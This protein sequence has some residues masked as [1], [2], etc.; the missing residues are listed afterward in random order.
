MIGLYP[1]YPKMINAKPNL[2]FFKDLE[3]LLGYKIYPFSSARA[4]LV[5]SLK[6]LGFDRMDEVLVPPFLSDCVISA[7]SKTAFPTM[8]AT[9]R[10]RAI[11]VFHQ[12]GFPQEIEVIE[13][14]AKQ[15]GWVVINCCVH[16]L[17]TKY[18]DEWLAGW[19]DFT[20]FSL[21]KLYPCGL[22]GGLIT[23]NEKIIKSLDE[24]YEKLFKLHEEW[25]DQAYTILMNT[26]H[27][28]DELNSHFNIESVYGYLPNTVTFPSAAYNGLPN[29]K[30][31]II[32]DIDRRKGLL[33]SVEDSLSGLTQDEKNGEV[34]PF[35]L[36]L[37][38]DQN[39]MRNIKNTLSKQFN[40]EAEILHFDYNQNMLNANYEKALVLGC[41]SSW[42][43]HI[44]EDLRSA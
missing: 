13:L 1:G 44:F 33:N 29:N 12:F 42:D 28:S 38:M 20:I 34:S 10:T 15:E 5:F 43:N 19:G 6:A 22:G 26:N 41:H 14:K 35:A 30:Q 7:I 23:N 32:K 3:S 17:F 27:A 8:V 4:A 2:G 40:T 37:K 11:Y 16:S 36:P 25:V 39:K 24:D 9:P 18:N 31:S 21:P